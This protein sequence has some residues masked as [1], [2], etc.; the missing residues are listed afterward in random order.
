MR[1]RAFER[2]RRQY[3]AT[4]RLRL[5]AKVFP[6]ELAIDDQREAP[7][8]VIARVEDTSDHESNARGREV[9]PGHDTILRARSLAGFVLA[10]GDPR[11]TALHGSAEWKR[12]HRA[13]G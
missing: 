8:L 10:S 3:F 2:E 13:R 11:S 6:R 9:P 5:G 1:A 4:D 12:A 7:G